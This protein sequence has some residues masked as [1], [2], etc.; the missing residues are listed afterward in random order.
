MSNAVVGSEAIL[1]LI[2]YVVS[3]SKGCELKRDDGLKET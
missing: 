3:F 2:E 1:V